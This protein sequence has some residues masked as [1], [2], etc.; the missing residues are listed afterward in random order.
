M[1]IAGADKVGGAQGCLPKPLRLCTV[2]FQHTMHVHY[3]LATQGV[4]PV[5]ALG[6]C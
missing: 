1:L 4:V 6:A 5:P 2:Q 3:D